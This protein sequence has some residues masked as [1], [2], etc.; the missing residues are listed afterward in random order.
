MI[1]IIIELL[2]HSLQPSELDNIIREVDADGELSVKLY[3]TSI[4]GKE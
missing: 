3:C 2:G 4:Y 1:G